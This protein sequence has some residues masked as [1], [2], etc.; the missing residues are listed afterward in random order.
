MENNRIFEFMLNSNS[1]F[2]LIEADYNQIESALVDALS[3]KYKIE[4]FYNHVDVRIFDSKEL[5]I[6]DVK[7]IIFEMGLRPFFSKKIIIF[8]NFEKIGE[9]SQNAMLKSIEEL[10]KDTLIISVCNDTISVLDTIKSRAYSVYLNREFDGLNKSSLKNLSKQEILKLFE[11]KLE[12]NDTLNILENLII[13]EGAYLKA[14]LDQNKYFKDIVDI[15]NELNKCYNYI[16]SNC[17]RNLCLD[18]LLYRILEEK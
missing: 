3:I 16:N 17:N 18:L 13:S 8:K 10:P 4:D 15:N 9:L 11:D 6:A 7:Q 14:N 1:S 5:Q 12:K 2:F